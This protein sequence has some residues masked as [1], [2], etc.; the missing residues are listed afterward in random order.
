MRGLSSRSLRYMATL[1]SRWP[2]GIGQRS[3]AQLPWGLVTTLLDSCPDQETS[4][5]YANRATAEG[6][7]R[8]V[9]QAMI[10]SRLHE[11]TQPALTTFDTSVPEADRDAVREIVRTRSSSTSSWRTRCGSLT[12][13]RRS[14]TT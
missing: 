2:D 3:V 8:G 13:P 10:A 12:C 9:L 4:E 11:R 5:F 14:P 7:T 1:A 6:W